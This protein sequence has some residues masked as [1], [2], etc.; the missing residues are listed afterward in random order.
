MDEIPKILE[1]IKNYTKNI[2]KNKIFPLIIKTNINHINVFH[3]QN[4]IY[5]DKNGIHDSYFFNNRFSKIINS[6]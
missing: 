3:N 1:D 5:L 4:I 2:L 6:F